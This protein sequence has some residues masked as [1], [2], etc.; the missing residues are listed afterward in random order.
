MNSKLCFVKTGNWLDSFEGNC[1]PFERRVKLAGIWPRRTKSFERLCDSFERDWRLTF[2]EV[3]SGFRSLIM[4]CKSLPRDLDPHKLEVS[5]LGDPV[6]LRK[7]EIPPSSYQKPLRSYVRPPLIPTED[8]QEKLE[9]SLVGSLGKLF[10]NTGPSMAEIFR[11]LFSFRKKPMNHQQQQ[12]IY[13]QQSQNRPNVWPLQESFA[14]RDEDGPPPLET[15]TPTSRKTYTFMSNDQEKSHRFHQ[16]CGYQG[17]WGEEY[18]YQYQQQQHHQR[19]YSS[20]PQTYYKE[21][22]ETTTNE[23]VFGAVQEQDGWRESVVIKAV[24]YSYPMDDRSSCTSLCAIVLECSL[25]GMDSFGDESTTDGSSA[26]PPCA[27]PPDWGGS[28]D[29]EADTSVPRDLEAEAGMNFMPHRR[30]SGDLAHG[31]LISGRARGGSESFWPYPSEWRPPASLAE[32]ETDGISMKYL[33]VVNERARA[34]GG[35]VWIWPDYQTLAPNQC[36]C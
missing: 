36:I 11:G 24:D 5:N 7:A 23:I 26:R 21:S 35:D 20:G 2:L 3:P 22:F 10:L 15:R 25:Q 19:H 18:Q 13:Y 12:N 33:D 14:I 6:T 28:H 34:S 1:R 8:E 9:E 4:R 31:E 16:N 27:I 32:Y 17:P 29:H 30:V